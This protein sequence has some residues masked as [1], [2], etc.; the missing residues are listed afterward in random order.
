MVDSRPSSGKF[1]GIHFV[2]VGLEEQGDG[3]LHKRIG[4][5]EFPIAE[6]FFDPGLER[7]IEGD[8][9]PALIVPPSFFSGRR[10]GPARNPASVLPAAKSRS[11][12]ET[13]GRGPVLLLFGQK[14]GPGEESGVD[15]AGDEVGMR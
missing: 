13:T 4:A 2:S 14:T 12:L 11:G 1:R 10:P 5:L 9:H 6:L 7:R 8:F 15:L 3:L